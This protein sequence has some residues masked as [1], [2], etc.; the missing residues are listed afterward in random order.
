V[1]TQFVY[2][3][4]GGALTRAPKA[5]G[6]PSV[7][8]SAANPN[9]IVVDGQNVYWWATATSSFAVT[10]TVNAAPK[11]GGTAAVLYT[12]SF[13][14]T[15][16]Q[17]LRFDRGLLQNTTS[18]FFTMIIPHGGG[19]EILQLPKAGGAAVTLETCGEALNGPGVSM[20][21]VDDTT[22]C[23]APPGRPSPSGPSAPSAACPPRP[24]HRS[25][26]TR[27]T[28]TSSPPS[29]PTPRPRLPPSSSSPTAR[30]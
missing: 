13:D 12:T 27:P 2:Y 19:D 7:V 26:T 21:D 10:T 25:C 28:S 4:N 11:A 5:G 20:F 18:L 3:A 29:R 9:G 6:S 14:T 8:V 30:P 24:P 17:G 23:P 22:L 15:N 16:L 1:D